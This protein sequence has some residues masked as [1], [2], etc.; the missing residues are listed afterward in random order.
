[1]AGYS[2]GQLQGEIDIIM[3]FL[4][5]VSYSKIVLDIEGTGAT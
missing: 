1:M 3:Y 2:H 4:L 5:I